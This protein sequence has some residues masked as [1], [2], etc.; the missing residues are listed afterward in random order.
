MML[1]CVRP[2]KVLDYVSNATKVWSY[3]MRQKSKVNIQM[4]SEKYEQIASNAMS[5]LIA[6][7]NG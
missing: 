5:K 7:N 4:L 6:E 1:C 2:E 3:Q